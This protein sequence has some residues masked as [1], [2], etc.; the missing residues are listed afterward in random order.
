MFCNV[1]QI[2]WPNLKFLKLVQKKS[3]GKKALNLF[4]DIGLSEF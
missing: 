2:I 3:A 4:S 1:L